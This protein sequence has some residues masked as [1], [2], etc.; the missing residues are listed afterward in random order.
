MVR[1]DNTRLSAGKLSGRFLDEPLSITLRPA[2]KDEPKLSH[3]AVLSGT[4]P[5]G[6]LAAAFSL[7]YAERLDGDV[8]WTATALVPQEKSGPPLRIDIE[9]DLVGLASTLGAPLQKLAEAAEPLQ[10]AVLFRSAAS[11]TYPDS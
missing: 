6:K 11:S 8:T 9:S 3:V 5:I 1:L 10:M 4:T 7:P 2:S